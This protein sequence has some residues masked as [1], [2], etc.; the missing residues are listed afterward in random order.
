MLREGLMFQ[1]LIG[2]LAVFGHNA[3]RGKHWFPFVDGAVPELM[4]GSIRH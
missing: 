1:D 3:Q 2:Y 4:D